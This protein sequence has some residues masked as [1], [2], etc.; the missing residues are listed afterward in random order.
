MTT[1][2]VHSNV[3]HHLSKIH[4]V[5][6][7]ESSLRL[8]L[9]SLRFRMALP[10][11]EQPLRKHY[12]I[13]SIYTF[14]LSH[15]TNEMLTEYHRSKL[16]QFADVFCWPTKSGDGVSESM[17]PY[18]AFEGTRAD[19]ERCCDLVLKDIC[20]NDLCQLDSQ[21]EQIYL[22]ACVKVYFET[23]WELK[24]GGGVDEVSDADSGES[25]NTGETCETDGR[26][27]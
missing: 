4:L 3:S 7:S 1:L 19:L 17:T 5:T 22:L 2:Q 16:P 6:G 20:A 13:T 8:R 11:P 9:L 26:S 10:P 14:E 15:A 23:L 25:S 18:N 24:P 21:Q 12:E 27:L